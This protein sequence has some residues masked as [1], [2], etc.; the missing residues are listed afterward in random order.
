MSFV[1]FKL[2][3]MNLQNQIKRTLSKPETLDYVSRLLEER[4]F[5]S[6]SELAGLLCDQL[7]FHD[8]GGRPQRGG[9]LKAL[10][11]LEA[12]GWF[13]LPPPRI[14]KGASS[15]RRLAGPVEEPSGVPEQVGEVQGLELIWVGEEEPMRIW[16]ELMIGE[17]PRGAG[18]LVGR[19]V[20][21]LV[22]SEHGWLGA[23]G[24]AAPALQ[25]ADRDRWIGP[26]RCSWRTGTAGS[27]GTPS[28]GEPI[29]TASC[30]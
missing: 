17:H 3:G 7:G 12:K 20:R 9:C 4:D 5:F 11:E 30:A 14:Q 10:R 22:G 16:N 2:S 27:V 26:Q 1:S 28:K 23:L 8:P 24:F 25:L 13:R 21:Y 18:P 29:C 6:R 19:Q 15:P